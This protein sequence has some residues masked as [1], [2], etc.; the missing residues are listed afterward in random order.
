MDVGLTPEVD[1]EQTAESR[2]KA[3]QERERVRVAEAAL[4]DNDVHK[5]QVKA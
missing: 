4:P 1:Q 5:R 2:K 3:R